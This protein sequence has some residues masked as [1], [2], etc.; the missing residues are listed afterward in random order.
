MAKKYLTLEEAADLI[1]VQTE[2]L[3]R[4]RERGQLRGFA[5]RGTWK[6]KHEDIE[7]LARSRQADS[8]P[9]VPILDESG[10]LSTDDDDLADQPTVIRR[11]VLDD[12]D[13][14]DDMSD[15]DVRLILDDSLTA[16][17][18][19]PDVMVI[20]A[21][22]DSD[23]ALVDESPR[24][25]D[26][27]D[28]D[29]KLIGGDSE[30]DV[31]LITPNQADS[32]SDVKL[33]PDA[34][35]GDDVDLHGTESEVRLLDEADPRGG[36]PGSD[37]DVKLIHDDNT[38]SEVA[39]ISDEGA[40]DSG[41]RLDLSDVSD[42]DDASVLADD[43]AI[44]LSDD[45]GISLAAESGI[46]LENLADSGISLESA[47]SGIALSPG[48]SGISLESG[49]SGLTLSDDDDFGLADDSGISVQ[50]PADS[51]IALD[52]GDDMT[53]TIPML[54]S[55]G[56]DSDFDQTQLEVSEFESADSEF[57]LSM[58][59]IDDDDDGAD[60]SVILFDDDDDVDDHAPTM[61]R[62]GADEF[63]DEDF[64]SSEEFADDFD[65][66]MDVAG[67]DVIGEDDELDDLDVFDAA[68]EDFDDGF[69]AGESHAEFISPVGAQMAAPAEADWG[70][71]TFVGLFLATGLLCLV[72]VVMFDLIRTMW[73]W[74]EPSSFSSTR[75]GN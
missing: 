22:S 10:V 24:G 40:A 37:S 51:G 11:N 39:V 67:V 68:D 49:D 47:D 41:V 66:D 18:S 65:D 62:G 70:A 61:V 13:V 42:D 64:D 1:G 75:T 69:T 35:G 63:D 21:D 14:R 25:D 36:D 55:P 16:D 58:D 20:G 72:G 2:E 53:E 38:D 74:N 17:D 73:A 12:D 60:T 45:S 6:F 59:A 71:G 4:L 26:G 44:A 33:I 48:E 23:V 52:S 30:S 31:Q 32:D 3:I 8:D 46:S 15:S 9:D 7:E 50:S 28:S 27:S 57:E 56:G 29:V 5:D 43:S 54:D 19:D 34:P